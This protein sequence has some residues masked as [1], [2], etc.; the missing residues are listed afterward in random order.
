M[1]VLLFFETSY[2]LQMRE[3]AERGGSPW[4]RMR[5]GGEVFKI[6]MARETNTV[7]YELKFLL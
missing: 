6:L 7:E 1:D 5:G 4:L 2:N 3:G